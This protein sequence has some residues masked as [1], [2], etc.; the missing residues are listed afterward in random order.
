MKIFS[1]RNIIGLAAIGGIYAFVRHQGGLQ[2]AY[3]T[4]V[5][6]KDA[7]L[8]AVPDHLEDLKTR[9]RDVAERSV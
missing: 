3:N 6:K 1:M 4:L 9:A 8:R 2:A 7:V 5:S